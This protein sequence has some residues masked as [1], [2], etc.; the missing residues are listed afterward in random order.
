MKFEINHRW[1]GFVL[2]T[3]E[4]SAEIAGREYG[5]RLGIA[6]KEAQAAGVSLSFAN[7]RGA[8]LRGANLSDADLS[9]ANLSD[10]DLS[11]ADLSYANLSGADL[12]DA[13][14]SGANL[15]GANLSGANLSDADLTPIRDDVWA[16]LAAAPGEARAVRDALAA[17]RVEGSVYAGDCACLVGTIA[18]ARGVAYTEIEGL[19]PASSRPAERFFMNIHR[20]DTPE[21]N[22]SCALA[23]EW[24]SDFVVRME[25]AFAPKV[26]AQP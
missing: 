24:A 20:G 21:N 4:L 3:C 6:I 2:Y 9:G 25:A 19:R 13:D 5:V 12:S 26:D 16:V 8:N 11:G 1:N 15:S 14:L 17:G 22:Q 10:A 18:N 7:L 23:H